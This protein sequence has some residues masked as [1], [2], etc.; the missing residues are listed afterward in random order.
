M[1]HPS[2]APNLTVV[3]RGARA[4]LEALLPGCPLLIDLAAGAFDVHATVP[5]DTALPASRADLE[6][7]A[8][9]L[10][11]LD[12]D[13]GPVLTELEGMPPD[14]AALVFNRRL[15]SD[16]DLLARALRLSRLA[17]AFDCVTR[18]HR[19]L[20]SRQG[21][22]PAVQDEILPLLRRVAG[23]AELVAEWRHAGL[24]CAETAARLWDVQSAIR[25]LMRGKAA[26]AV[27][28]LAAEAGSA[29]CRVALA[30]AQAVGQDLPLALKS[31]AEAARLRPDDAELAELRDAVTRVT[32]GARAV[33]APAIRAG[34]TLDGWRLEAVLG[35]GGWGQVFRA[36]RG[37]RRAALKVMHPEL[38]GD[39][40]F[41]ER[42]RREILTLAG[43]PAHPN[44]VR[45]LDFGKDHGCWFFVMDLIEGTSLERY[46]QARGPLSAP[47]ARRL[48]DAVADGLAL[49]HERGIV[50][51]DIKPSNILIRPDGSPVLVDFGIAGGDAALSALTR[52]GQ[53]AGYTALFASP[54]QLRGRVVDV[55]SDVYSMAASLYYAVT[56]DAETRRGKAGDDFDGEDVS[57]DLREVLAQGLSVRADRRQ[58]NAAE[59]R[60]HLRVRKVI[61]SAP[62]PAPAKL[63]APANGNLLYLP[64]AEGASF[65]C[66]SVW[67]D[68]KD[69]F[70][71]YRDPEATLCRDGKDLL[72]LQL[73]TQQLVRVPLGYN[74]W[75]E[76]RTPKME[77]GKVHTVYTRGH[78]EVCYMNYLLYRC[79]NDPRAPV[80]ELPPGTFKADRWRCRVEGDRLTLGYDPDGVEII[81]ERDH[82]EWHAPGF[83]LKD[84]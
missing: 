2:S 41:A 49:V 23:V 18:H 24:S 25:E 47:Q 15:V 69:L 31:L 51:R 4:V 45:I 80:H 68:G 42:F 74:G 62:P 56:Y 65:G 57:A 27:S 77:V 48:F 19:E 1:T 37:E 22:A 36:A 71:L 44:L 11:A 21:Y 72:A 7:L 79:L 66:W 52:A 50:H 63:D 84:R 28:A 17:V 16:D 14:E 29:A 26:A 34:M 3:T 54:E 64:L 5:A 61:E 81:F 83:K 70:V 58:A 33:S 78:L 82:P 38:S 35:A 30:A 40:V 10:A 46:L 39:P 76:Y 59:L 53:S 75:W 67:L 60:A 73:M 9:L 6:R 12:R 13:F 32:G 20:L 55:R 8:L 43:L